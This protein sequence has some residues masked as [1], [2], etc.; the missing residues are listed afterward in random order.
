ME[1]SSAMNSN[2]QWSLFLLQSS[3]LE[4]ILEYGSFLPEFAVI[5]SCSEHLLFLLAVR[6]LIKFLLEVLV[7][8]NPQNLF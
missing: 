1:S 5:C 8:F 2:G 4:A 7:N 3:R 6:V